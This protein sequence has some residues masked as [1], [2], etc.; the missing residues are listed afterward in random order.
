[1]SGTALGKQQVA[2]NIAGKVSDS[3]SLDVL[4][5]RLMEVVTETLGADRSSL[6]LLDPDTGELFSRIMQGNVIGEVRLP[7]AAGLFIGC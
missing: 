1:M 2:D 4:I 3:L 6:F 5:P 7:A